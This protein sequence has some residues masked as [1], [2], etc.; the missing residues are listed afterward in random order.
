MGDLF[1][2]FAPLKREKL[3]LHLF[4]TSPPFYGKV[5]RLRR[6]NAPP[7][8]GRLGFGLGWRF[9]LEGFQMGQLCMLFIWDQVSLSR[10]VRFW[11]LKVVCCFFSFRNFSEWQLWQIEWDMFFIARMDGIQNCLVDFNRFTVDF[12][13]NPMRCWDAPL[14]NRKRHQLQWSFLKNPWWI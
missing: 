12:W 7:W 2:R 11:G 13:V 10:F 1:P 3:L 5:R 8:I 14:K 6:R 9:P 4:G